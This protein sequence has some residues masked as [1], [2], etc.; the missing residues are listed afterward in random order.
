MPEINHQLLPKYLKDLTADPEKQFAPV[1]LVFGE[2]LLVKTAY[3]ALLDALLPKEGRHANY[4]PME[5]AA[6]NVYDAIERVNTFSLI[7]GIKVVALLESR[8]FHTTQDKTRL[9]ENAQKAYDDDNKS[10]AANY[11]LSLMGN[12]SLSFEDIDAAN[13]RKTLA[14]ASDMLKNDS[15]LDDLVEY[16]RQ[17]QLEIP[18]PTDPTG[19]L[20][21]AIKKGFPPDNHLVITTEMVDKRVGLYKALKD[22]G[23]VVDC[24][25]P[26]GDRRADRMAQEDVLRKKMAEI[27][28][29][30]NKKMD[31]RAFAALRDMTGFDLRTFCGNLE[32]LVNYVGQ[33]DAITVKDVASVL[34][35][36]KQDPIYELT[37]AIADRQASNALFL[38]KSLL[39]SRFH[40]LQVLAAIVNQIRRLILAKDYTTSPASKEWHAGVSYAVFQQNI[41]PS[42]LEYDKVLLQT[43]EKWEQSELSSEDVDPVSVRSKAKK[44][45]KIQT[46]LMLARNPKNA[47]PVYQLLKKS[48]RFSKSELM[49]AVEHLNE[50]DIQLKTSSQDPRLILERLVLKI[51]HRQT[52]S[53]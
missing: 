27:L 44:K 24:R 31:T 34:K 12:L 4:D 3:G 28:M 9:I 36:T 5:G 21:K 51:C 29:P 26:K 45:R 50:T 8:I 41:M 16:C 25:V 19:A 18:R 38:M 53:T 43:L 30:V 22:Q 6:E 48:D 23:V 40:P 47:Y 32:K 17:N 7:P 11:L 39:D 13:R 14:F 42:I 2:E 1:Y 15:W 35:R 52:E 37:N 20:Q 46:D 10:K 49:A 33:R